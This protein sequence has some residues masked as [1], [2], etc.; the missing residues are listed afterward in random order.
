MQNM[1]LEL[2]L[3]DFQLKAHST[4]R[5]KR[6]KALINS[7]QSSSFANWS[8]RWNQ[9]HSGHTNCWMSL[10]KGRYFKF[11]GSEL[12]SPENLNFLKFM[13]QF[14]G[15]GYS[16]SSLV[17]S[18]NIIFFCWKTVIIGTISYQNSCSFFS[19]IN[20]CHFYLGICFKEASLL[21]QKISHLIKFW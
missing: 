4:K 7:G 14:R 17:S 1:T 10:M 6:I 11:R 21:F 9:L 20:S 16:A 19:K 12:A 18:R 5:R 13:Q 8:V 15:I 3:S 2:I